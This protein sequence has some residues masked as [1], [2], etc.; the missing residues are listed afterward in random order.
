MFHPANLTSLCFQFPCSLCCKRQSFSNWKEVSG[1][2]HSHF[3]EKLWMLPLQ[4]SDQIG[5]LSQLVSK[6][7]NVSVCDGCAE[8]VAQK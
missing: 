1:F 8:S 3:K 2:W 4:G 7:V 6:K 5:V